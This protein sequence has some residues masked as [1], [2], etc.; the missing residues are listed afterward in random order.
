MVESLLRCKTLCTDY[1]A[2]MSTSFLKICP[3]LQPN[4]PGQQGTNS[5]WPNAR[6]AASGFSSIEFELPQESQSQTFNRSIDQG[7]R[8]C[9]A[10]Q[11]QIPAGTIVQGSLEVR[12]ILVP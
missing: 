12:D 11:F 1:A 4:Q 7:R 10:R 9:T 3:D 8:F 5:R 6:G 2:P